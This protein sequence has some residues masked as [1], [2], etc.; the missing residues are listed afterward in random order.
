[1][2]TA[3]AGRAHPARAKCPWGGY[4]KPRRPAARDPS[5]K[6][7]LPGPGL[8]PLPKL[9]AE[10][11]YLDAVWQ[12]P[13]LQRPPATR[14]RGGG[15]ANFNLLR[16]YRHTLLLHT[17]FKSVSFCRTPTDLHHMAHTHK[18]YQQG[19]LTQQ[20]KGE[21][22]T[23]KQ[24][25]L[26]LQKM[27]QLS[28]DNISKT[29]LILASQRG[30]KHI[31]TLLLGAGAQPNQ[32]SKC[33]VFF[34]IGNIRD[35]QIFAKQASRRR[36]PRQAARGLRLA[37]AALRPVPR[38]APYRMAGWIAKLLGSAELQEL[39]SGMIS[40]CSVPLAGLLTRLGCM[41]SRSERLGSPLMN[42]GRTRHARGTWADYLCRTICAGSS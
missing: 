7:R 38:T 8:F 25:G 27:T 22:E 10:D 37:G 2:N 16:V 19:S 17:R 14:H 1:M 35:R 6:G 34:L 9:P 15:Q 20:A 31:V 28:K 11:V 24:S 5:S 26:A 4:P 36:G 12:Q 13:L 32:A 3:R 39:R 42:R 30:H 41:A 33:M 23:K 29:A 18:Q 21:P 40:P